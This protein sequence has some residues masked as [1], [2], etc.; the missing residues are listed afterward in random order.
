MRLP[1][2]RKQQV[3]KIK[4]SLEDQFKREAKLV[5]PNECYAIMLGHVKGGEKVVDWLLFPDV[6]CNHS[7]PDYV[8]IREEWWRHAFDVAK[9]KEMVVLGDIH[10]HC[11]ENVTGTRD[12]SP[13]EAD[14]D[15][16]DRNYVMGICTITKPPN[17][18][19]MRASI[20]YWEVAP[21]VTKKEG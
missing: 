6:T 3:V 4:A 16:F 12:C 1:T 7:T 13:S 17:S 20:R 14:W 19:R 21:R 5:F 18:D 2:K 15:R 11:Y 8:N 10:S 9:L